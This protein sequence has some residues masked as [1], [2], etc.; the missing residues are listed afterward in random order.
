RAHF[1]DAHR[2]AVQHHV[3]GD[4]EKL[5]AVGRREGAAAVRLVARARGAGDAEKHC[6]ESG[7]PHGPVSR[8]GGTT[9]GSILPRSRFQSSCAEAAASTPLTTSKI[10]FTGSVAKTEVGVRPCV[11]VFT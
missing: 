2:H 8:S 3:G 10:V 9:S 4:V 11:W 5:G 6:E 7:A 1:L